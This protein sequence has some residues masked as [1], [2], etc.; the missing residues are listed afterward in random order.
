M[1]GYFLMIASVIGMFFEA[2]SNK[3]NKI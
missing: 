3:G 2:F 1:V